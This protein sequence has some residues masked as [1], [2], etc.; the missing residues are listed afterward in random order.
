[1]A[2]G[3]S[4][5]I[6][7]NHGLWRAAQALFHLPASDAYLLFKSAVILQCP[8]AV[9]A[10]W[11]L[12]RELTR[13]IAAATIAALL[14][15]TSP[16]YV[17]YS[18]QVMT[19][20]PS[21]LLTALALYLH[22]RGLRKGRVWMMLAGAA[23]LGLGVNVREPVAFY[24]PWLVIAPFVCGPEQRQRDRVLQL[25]AACMVF[26]VFA[27]GPFLLSRF[28]V[29]L[30]RVYA[31]GIGASSHQARQCSALP[32]IFLSRRSAGLSLSAVRIRQG[33]ARA[34]RPLLFA[35][36]GRAWVVGQPAADL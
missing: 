29:W 8:L 20:I 16:A 4:L 21:L 23:L 2:L 3:R 36:D 14:I 6:F 7:V 33:V 31:D 18:G 9:I 34:S 1:M 13:S 35:D 25:I 19:E 22:L 24:A 10:C 17:V 30:A 15:A 26:F 32:L 5:F 12:A 27:F 11:A 28:V